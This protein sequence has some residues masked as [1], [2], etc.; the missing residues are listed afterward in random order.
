MDYAGGPVLKET[1]RDLRE[2][3]TSGKPF[4]LAVGFTKPHLP[5]NAP[6]KYWDLFMIEQK[7]AE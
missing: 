2:A 7:L 6:K 3:K 4:F 5:F 1:I